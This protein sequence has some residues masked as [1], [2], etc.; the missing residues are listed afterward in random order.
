MQQ[1]YTPDFDSCKK[2][3]PYLASTLTA[4]TCLGS[5]L[6]VTSVLMK[7]CM[8]FIYLFIFT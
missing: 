8:R 2:K 7:P 5:Y 3:K 4:L 1:Y 6:N